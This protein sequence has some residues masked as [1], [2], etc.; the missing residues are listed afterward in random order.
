MDLREVPPSVGAFAHREPVNFVRL[1]PVSKLLATVNDYSFITDPSDAATLFTPHHLVEGTYT[2]LLRPDATV[3]ATGFEFWSR[4]VSVPTLASVKAALPSSFSSE[5][6][7]LDE[8]VRRVSRE[9]ARPGF[10]PIVV[11]APAFDNAEPFLVADSH[12][13][14][15]VSQIAVGLLL[16]GQNLLAPCGLSVS[17]RASVHVRRS[18]LICG[19]AVRGVPRARCSLRFRR[20]RRAR[21]TCGSAGH[22][23]GPWRSCSC[24]WPWS[25]CCR[26]GCRRC[27]RSGGAFAKHRERRRCAAWCRRMAQH[28]L[29]TL[30]R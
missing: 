28:T 22:F 24:C 9:A 29:Q 27:R 30:A 20:R 1:L 14:T 6:C 4:Y 18:Y 7:S 5:R 26:R 11:R 19:F 3:A 16:D 8:Y 23:G 17:C 2:R 21:R 13:D 25:C 10:A 12:D 15:W